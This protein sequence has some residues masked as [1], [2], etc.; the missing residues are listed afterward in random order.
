MEP[1]AEGATL[2]IREDAYSETVTGDFPSQLYLQGAQE[3]PGMYQLTVTKESYRV[4]MRDNVSVKR[5]TCN[6]IPVHMTAL[7]ERNP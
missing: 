5:G 1:A 4:W 6:V 7:L 3:R 2:V